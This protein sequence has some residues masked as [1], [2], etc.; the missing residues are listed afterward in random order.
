MGAGVERVDSGSRLASHNV[1]SVPCG[2]RPTDAEQIP[3]GRAL[4]LTPTAPGPR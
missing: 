3:T 2:E 4:H 1:A